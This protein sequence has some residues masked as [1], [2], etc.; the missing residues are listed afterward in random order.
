[1]EFAVIGSAVLFG[2]VA[3]NAGWFLAMRALGHPVRGNFF[4]TGRFWLEQF[5]AVSL[6]GSYAV[7][8]LFDGFPFHPTWLPTA[9]LAAVMT[10][11]VHM[12]SL[13]VWK[14]PSVCDGRYAR[15]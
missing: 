9:A 6:Y 3:G 15:R 1:M 13:A 2:L 8:A 14:L 5:A 10:V 11:V 7:V 4:R 12:V